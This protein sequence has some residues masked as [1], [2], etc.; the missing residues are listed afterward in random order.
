MELTIPIK[1]EVDDKHL[2]N[3]IDKYMRENPDMVEVVR[4]KDC[5]NAICSEGYYICCSLGI[6]VDGDFYCANGERKEEK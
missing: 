6:R 5:Q 4:C 2:E 3:A 1:I